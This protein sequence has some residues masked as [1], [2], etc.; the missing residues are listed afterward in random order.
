MNN[1]SKYLLTKSIAIKLLNEDCHRKF[2]RIGNCKKLLLHLGKENICCITDL[3]T[4]KTQSLLKYTLSTKQD[5][6]F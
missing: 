1:E 3:N 5:E 4:K 2:C 6:F